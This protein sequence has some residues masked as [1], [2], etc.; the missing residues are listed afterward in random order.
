VPQ[1]WYASSSLLSICLYFSHAHVSSCPECILS[2]IRYMHDHGVVHRDLKF[3]NIMFESQHPE[4]T[5]KVID[6]GLSK[7][8]LGETGFMTERVG[9]IYVRAFGVAQ[10]VV[11]PLT[12]S[13]TFVSS[14]L[15]QDHGTSS[16]AGHVFF[17]SRYMEV[18][19]CSQVF[20]KDTSNG[21][22][23]QSFFVHSSLLALFSLLFISTKYW[24]PCFHASL[25]VKTVLPQAPPCG[26]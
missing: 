14:C 20:R 24:S 4:A 10:K 19:V 13:V 21:V 22:V 16:L 7:K 3:E 6:F 15:S 23:A 25:F 12:H 1:G 2:A 17:E 26:D 9:T 18:G 11:F 5:I 8:F